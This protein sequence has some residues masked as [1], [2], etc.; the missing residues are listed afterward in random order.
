M[1]LSQTGKMAHHFWRQIPI[2]FPFILLDEFV[3]MPNHMHG[4]LT[5]DKQDEYDNGDGVDVAGGNGGGDG[6]DGNGGDNVETRQCLVSGNT[7]TDTE[8]G[9]NTHQN[10]PKTPGQKRFRNQGKHTISSIIGSYKSIVTRHAR[11]I[12][13]NFGWQSRFHDHIIRNE[14]AYRN[15]RQYII[16]NPQKWKSDG[17]Y[18]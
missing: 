9:G 5:I 12:N 10:T 11:K 16:D 1:F 7:D 14:T 3:I 15:I 13:P 4:I 2:H 18:W 17:F 8:T 6:D